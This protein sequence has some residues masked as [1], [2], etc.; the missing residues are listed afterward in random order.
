MDKMT[1]AFFAFVEAVCFSAIVL[2]ALI[3]FGAGM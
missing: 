1:D 2:I 3:T